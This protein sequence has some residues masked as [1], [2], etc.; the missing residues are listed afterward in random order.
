MKCYTHELDN[1]HTHE[2]HDTSSTG[3]ESLRES[4][5]HLQKF[6]KE[7]NTKYNNE[8]E[9]VG[10][11]AHELRS[12]IMPILGTL[13]SIEYEYKE[14]SKKEVKLQREHFERLVRN[15]RRLE[16]LSS[17]ILDVTKIISI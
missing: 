15:S 16:R 7:L 9:F 3:N 14:S 11:A 13:E 10:L 5:N 8:R 12:P 2:L 4:I 17:E 6:N 1:S